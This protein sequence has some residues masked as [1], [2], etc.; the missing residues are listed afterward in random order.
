MKMLWSGIR[1][2]VNLK[3][4]KTSHL[5]HLLKDGSRI[6]DPNKNGKHFQSICY[7]WWLK[8]S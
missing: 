4:K 5:S 3:N 1:S 8:Y 7:K 2:I 6:T